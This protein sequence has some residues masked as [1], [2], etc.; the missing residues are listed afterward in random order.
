MTPT[1]TILH[2][3]DTHIL[4]GV[5]DRLHGVDTMANL[6]LAFDSLEEHAARPDAIVVSGDLTNGGE[7]DSYRRLRAVLDDARDRFG[8]PVLPVMGNHDARGPFRAGLLGVAACDE[9][10][11]YVTWVG[12]LRVIV[13][14]STVP[15]AAHGE[16]DGPQL[17]WLRTELAAPAPEGTIVAVHHP[18]IPG[19]VPVINYLVLQNPAALANVIRDSDVL[20]VLAGHAHHPISGVFAGVLCFAAP[21]TAYTVDPLAGEARIRGI[22]GPGFGLVQLYGRTVVASA[23]SLRAQPTEL[24]V[25][26]VS[27]EVISR[28]TGRTL[29]GVNGGRAG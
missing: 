12:D 10:F 16:L 4:P 5:D 13:L 11:H 29:V 3:S 1:R 21:A 9:P 17:D 22:D 25:H 28:W 26:Q 2:L 23:A 14:D 24:Y 18:P 20:A 7:L 15:G 6:R 27:A 8:V 19:P